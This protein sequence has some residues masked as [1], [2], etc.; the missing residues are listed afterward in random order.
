MEFDVDIVWRAIDQSYEDNHCPLRIRKPNPWW[1]YR[2][3][4]LKKEPRRLFSRARKTV[5][6]DL[7]KVSVARYA[8]EIQSAKRSS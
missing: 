4:A 5:N 6:W 2:L 8:N 3:K 7:Y 1:N